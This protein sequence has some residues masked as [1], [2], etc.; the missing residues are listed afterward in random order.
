L[1]SSPPATD[2]TGAMGREIESRLGIR[3]LAVFFRK[4]A[5]AAWS[6][7]IVSDCAVMGREIESRQGIWL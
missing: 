1:V 4:E 3:W 2:E 5:L 7:G 6:S